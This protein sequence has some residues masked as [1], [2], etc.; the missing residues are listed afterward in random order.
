[1]NQTAEPTYQPRL[2]PAGRRV[3]EAASELFYREGLRA[4]GVEHIAQTAGVTKKTLYDCFGSKEELITTY[5]RCRDGNWRAWLADFVDRNADTPADKPLTV[6]DGV[7]YW[8]QT[9]NT[10]GCAFINASAEL[11]EDA[12]SARIAIRAQKQ[13]MI[14]YLTDLVAQAGRPEPETLGR[15]LFLLQEAAF[16]ADGTCVPDNAIHLVK[17][18]AA[19]LIGQL[20]HRP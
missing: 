18:T 2:T 11:P 17:D 8:Q 15:Q 13:W 6:F 12:D 4:V 9:M 1:M 16:V 10:R 20:E 3:L 7:A 14:D 5:L 19:A